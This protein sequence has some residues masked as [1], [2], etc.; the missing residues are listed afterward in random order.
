MTE[1]SRSGEGTNTV[2]KF[3]MADGTIVQIK[4]I[5]PA[6][7][8]DEDL[9]D[10]AFESGWYIREEEHDPNTHDPGPLPTIEAAIAYLAHAELDG[11][12]GW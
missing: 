7:I 4:H 2:V 1:I 5:S 3:R 12:W 11:G 10:D 9:D 6:N 8:D